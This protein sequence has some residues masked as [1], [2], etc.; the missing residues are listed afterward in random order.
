MKSLLKFSVKQRL[1]AFFL[2]L[3]VVPTFTVGSISYLTT[4]NELTEEQHSS[5]EQSLQLIDQSISAFI[6]PKLNQISTLAAYVDEAMLTNNEP[7]LHVLFDEYLA[8]NKDVSIIYIGTTDK[9]MIRRPYFEY[10]ASY[11]PTARPWY[12]AAMESKGQPIITEPYISSSSGELVITIAQTLQNGLG[13][14]GLDMSI[15][16]LSA[17]TNATKIGE[18][19]YFTLL[20]SVHQYIVHP[21]IESGTTAEQAFIE[22]L[23][24]NAK[25]VEDEQHTYVYK[26]NE[27]TNWHLV[28]AI[29]KAETNDASNMILIVNITIV[30]SFLVIGVI[31]GYF[32]L[33]SILRPLRI[34]TEQAE[35]ISN[36][37]LT[38]SL[39]DN[40]KNDEIG[41]LNNMFVQMRDNLRTLLSTVKDQSAELQNSSDI[42]RE[43]SQQ[44]IAASEQTAMAIQAVASGADDQLQANIKNVET[45]NATQA[46]AENMTIQSNEIQQLT[47]VA[48][49]EA[50]LGIDVVQSTVKQIESVQHSVEVSSNKMKVLA[51]NVDQIRSIIGMI[52]DIAEQ[53]NLLALN[54]S[55]EA[56]RAGEHGKGFA[57]VA[58]EVGNLAASSRQSTEQIRHLI[59]TII[60]DTESS[61][62]IMETANSDMHKGLQLTNE[63]AEK[64]AVISDQL[65]HIQP[66]VAHMS[67]STQMMTTAMAESTNEANRLIAYAEQSAASSEEVAASTEQI[68]ASMQEI[69]AASE[70]LQQ[71]VEALSKEVNRFKV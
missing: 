16:Q 23:T 36:G 67:K 71:M 48:M 43:G 21:T 9:Q 12:E 65:Q 51:Q 47:K 8:L 34:L 26:Q 68:N 49:T 22:L 56:A 24:T 37:D 70:T 6:Q 38:V 11:D 15:E 31:V 29:H 32:V 40:M 39:S 20:D 62:K 61:A 3:L 69:G 59:Q 5:A 13:V 54:A 55:I 66:V 35:Q 33:V 30:L 2:V 4:K 42:L 19:G 17:L 50:E 45:L 18:Q 58:Q 44:T 63:T 27:A 53:T 41:K 7:A 14:V 57:V 46:I 64:F 60:S 25:V 10:D 28:G 1:I 52:T